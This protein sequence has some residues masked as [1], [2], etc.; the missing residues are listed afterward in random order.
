MNNIYS[1]KNTIIH[2][3]KNNT[4]VD[5]HINAK[6]KIWVSMLDRHHESGAG[7]CLFHS[8]MLTRSWWC[9]VPLHLAHL[10]DWVP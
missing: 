8:N 4:S 2:E 3:K 7:S 6:V 5:N 10:E 9:Y 1:I